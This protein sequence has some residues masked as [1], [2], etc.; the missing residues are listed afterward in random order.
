MANTPCTLSG[1]GSPKSL[2]WPWGMNQP[3]VWRLSGLAGP[4]PAP[5]PFGMT[6]GGVCPRWRGGGETLETELRFVRV[7]RAGPPFVLGGFAG[8]IAF[9]GARERDRLRENSAPPAPFA[10]TGDGVCRC[11]FA[12]PFGG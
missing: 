6:S 1:V 4:L 2:P 10:E 12:C 3:L 9:D 11:P 7:R 8:S 5:L